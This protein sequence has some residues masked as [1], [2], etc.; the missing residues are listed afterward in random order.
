[1]ILPIMHT[2]A[3]RKGWTR[4]NVARTVVCALVALGLSLTCIVAA[5]PRRRDNFMGS[6]WMLPTITLSYLFVLILTH[7][8]HPR[9][10]WALGRYTDSVLGPGGGHGPDP[11]YREVS[12]KEKQGR[13]SKS[14]HPPKKR[15]G[16]P[17]AAYNRGSSY[18][19]EDRRR[20]RPVDRRDQFNG[21][22]RHQIYDRSRQRHVEEDARTGRRFEDARDYRPGR[23]VRPPPLPPRNLQSQSRSRSQSYGE[24]SRRNGDDAGFGV[25]EDHRINMLADDIERMITPSPTPPTSPPSSPPLGNGGQR[26]R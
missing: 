24:H 5:S 7:V 10:R 6:A 16:A 15:R 12:M 11:E 26:R 4:F 18:S 21:P 9:R 13:R 19:E 1:M 20:Y 22:A 3:K 23:G 2:L 25:F 14:N 8:R 17:D